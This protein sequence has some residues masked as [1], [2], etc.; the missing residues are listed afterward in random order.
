LKRHRILRDLL[1]GLTATVFACAFGAMW[2][3][4]AHPDSRHAISSALTL[5]NLRGITVD[6]DQSQGVI[7]LSGIVASHSLRDLAHQLA[8]KAAP[9]YAIDNQIQVNRAGLL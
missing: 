9:G 7:R 5:H 1:L 3:S 8:Q 6:Q 4:S 2:H